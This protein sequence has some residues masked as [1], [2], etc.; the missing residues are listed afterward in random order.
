MTFG[1]FNFHRFGIRV[2]LFKYLFNLFS[3]EID[4]IIHDALCILHMF[5][6]QIEIEMSFA[7]KRIHYIGVEID[8][9]KS[10]AVVRTERDFSARIRG[11]RSE[12]KIRIAVRN[13]F[14]QD[15]IPKENTWLC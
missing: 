1:L 5:T 2:Y 12:S 11:N 9:E 3:F 14:S 13:G 6:E 8:G 4:D 7:G 10:A 15:R